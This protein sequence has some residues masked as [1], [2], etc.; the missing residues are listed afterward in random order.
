[1][2]ACTPNQ[3]GDGWDVYQQGA[4]LY[5]FMYSIGTNSN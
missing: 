2:S 4:P 1:M 3:L 5:L